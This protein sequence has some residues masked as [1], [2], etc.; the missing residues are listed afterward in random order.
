ML[1]RMVSRMLSVCVGEFSL[2]VTSTWLFSCLY[3][4]LRDRE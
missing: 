3:S 4:E 1:E 2:Q